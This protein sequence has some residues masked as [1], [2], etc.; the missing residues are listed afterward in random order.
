MENR[1]Q[2]IDFLRELKKEQSGFR[3]YGFLFGLL[4]VVIAAFLGI[5]TYLTIKRLDG[6][7]TTLLDAR[8]T[9]AQ[10]LIEL[11]YKLRDQETRNTRQVSVNQEADDTRIFV[12]QA[13][14]AALY[15]PKTPAEQDAINRQLAQAALVYA[16]A[17][18]N[19]TP[20]PYDLQNPGAIYNGQLNWATG[21]MLTQALNARSSAGRG[22][23]STDERRIVQAARADWLGDVDGAR[24]AF[25]ALAQARTTEAKALGHVGLATLAYDMANANTEEPLGWDKG[26]EAAVDAA[27]VATQQY[28]S[29]AASVL[30]AIGACL[31]KAGKT[32]QA[33]KAFSEALD[34]AAPGDTP[35]YPTSSQ[36]LYEAYHGVGTTLIAL[37]NAPELAVAA[38]IT[39]PEGPSAEARR[40]LELAAQYRGEWGMTN[41]GLVY[42]LE[43]LCFIYLQQGDYEGALAHTETMDRTLALAWNLTCRLVA[44]S[45]LAATADDGGMVA[46][47]SV[48]DLQDIAQKAVLKLSLFGYGYFDEKELRRLMPDAHMHYVDAALQSVALRLELGPRVAFQQILDGALGLDV[49]V[50]E[51]LF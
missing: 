14:T 46:G 7:S 19:G 45:E 36:Q 9:N 26:C 29:H 39:L 51:Q 30:I 28:D 4:F 6:V 31:R 50:E 49:L 34:L 43:N 32:A 48:D 21:P 25:T 17:H 23:F 38:D 12:A 41:V 11:G 15:G 47:Y 16:K 24:T 35:V 8:I 1:T 13:N 27:T 44:A 3:I 2:H 22:Y 33:Y 40:L 20:L 10:V 42:S 18:I 37:A 5:S